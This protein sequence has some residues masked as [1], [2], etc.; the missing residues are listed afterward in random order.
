MIIQQ[1]TITNSIQSAIVIFQKMSGQ[2]VN[3][4]VTTSQ[5]YVEGQGK[6]VYQ[7]LG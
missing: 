2:Q 5:Q 6:L 1:Q 3:L 7:V 4:A